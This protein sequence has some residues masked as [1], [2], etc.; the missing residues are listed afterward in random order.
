ML[1]RFF[2]VQPKPNKL[3]KNIVTI[4]NTTGVCI[5]AYL[6]ISVFIEIGKENF[7]NKKDLK[8]SL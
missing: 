6:G 8:K 7:Q 1:S 5:L 4:G 2:K 3:V